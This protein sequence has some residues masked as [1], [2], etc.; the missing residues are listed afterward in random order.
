MIIDCDSC[1]ARDIA[2][3]DCVITALRG[4]PPGPLELDRD[5]RIAFVRLAAA[6]LVPPLRLR[7]GE[8]GG[9]PSAS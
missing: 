8:P 4:A 5:E 7:P 6:G 1:C 2:C 3:D 9:L